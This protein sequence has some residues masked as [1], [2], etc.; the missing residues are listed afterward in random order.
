VYAAAYIGDFD[1]VIGV[2]NISALLER[3]EKR[4]GRWERFQGSYTEKMRNIVFDWVEDDFMLNGFWTDGS[5]ILLHWTAFSNDQQRTVAKMLSACAEGTYVVSFTNP[6]PGKRSRLR[7]V[8]ALLTPS[9]HT[10]G[11][12]PQRARLSTTIAVQ[13]RTS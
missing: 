1:R 10:N 11:T 12:V 4:A 8:S 13:A 2:E 5:F 3:G 9:M 6:I 7:I